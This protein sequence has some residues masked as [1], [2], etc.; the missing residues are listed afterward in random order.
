MHDGQN[1][2]DPKTAFMGNAWRIQDT[3]DKLIYTG[4]IEEV[5]VIGIYNTGD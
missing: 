3:L 5:V 4:N 2:F 1:L